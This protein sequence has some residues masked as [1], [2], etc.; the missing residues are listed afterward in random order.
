MVPRA[1]RVS[2]LPPVDGKAQ[3]A[4]QSDCRAGFI[5]SCCHALMA[6]GLIP[7]YRFPKEGNHLSSMPPGLSCHCLY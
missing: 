1:Q 2:L 5:L 6:G 3:V 4:R 7:N